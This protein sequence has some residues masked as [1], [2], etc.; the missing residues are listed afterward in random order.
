MTSTKNLLACVFVIRHSWTLNMYPK[1][2]SLTCIMILYLMIDCRTYRER[3]AQHDVEGGP[4]P[5]H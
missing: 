5:S 1:C 2:V 3:H 4:R